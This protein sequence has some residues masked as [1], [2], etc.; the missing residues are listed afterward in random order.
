MDRKKRMRA[1]LDSLFSSAE[2][3]SRSSAPA[4]GSKSDKQS[5]ADKVESKP[6]TRAP[7]SKESSQKR[8]I[9]AGSIRAPEI[10]QQIAAEEKTGDQIASPKTAVEAKTEIKPVE[11][12]SEPEIRTPDEQ[13]KQISEK[14]SPK[15]EPQQVEKVEQEVKPPLSITPQKEQPKT[16]APVRDTSTKKAEINIVVFKLVDEYYSIDINDVETIIKMQAITVVPHTSAHVLGVTNLRG[17]VLP[18]FDLR[19]RFGLP[20]VEPTKDTRII[21]VKVNNNM[22]GIVVDVVV[23]VIR[24]SQ[25]K[26]EITPTIATTVNSRY[27]DGVINMDDRLVILLNLAKILEISAKI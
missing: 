6:K 23:E 8:T 4:S 25:E 15:L 11:T 18:V 20:D 3:E 10:L 17:I 2:E 14:P 21:V 22:V 26:I 24:V 12:V 19:R 1:A 16:L 27:V 13:V 5:I 9:S 7:K